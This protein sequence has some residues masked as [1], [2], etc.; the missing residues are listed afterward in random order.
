MKKTMLLLT[1]MSVILI[2][3]CKNI[4]FEKTK[5]GMEYKIYNDGKGR[6]LKKGDFVKFDYKITYNDSLINSSYNFIPG[7]DEVDTVGRYHDFSEV[8]SKMKIGDSLVCFQFVDSLMTQNQF[9]IPPY[10]KKGGKQ[11]MTIK[12]LDAFEGRENAIVD[13]QKE[14]EAYKN[15]ELKVIEKYL[16]TNKINAKNIGDKVY[17]EMISEGT[18]PAADSG[19][20]VGIKYTGY[21]L[22]GK[23]FDSNTDSTKQLQKHGMELFYFVAKQEGSVTGMLE[24]I[25]Q[26]KQGGKGRIFIPSIMAYGPQGNPPAIKS[27]ENIYFDIELVEVKDVPQQPAGPNPMAPG[28]PNGGQ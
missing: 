27:N 16:A 15:S 3:S 18:G 24:G 12:I 13:Y 11:K 20:L 6:Q 14:I 25:T 5:T 17:V 10:M 4:G 9:G 1:V 22:E 7:F 26:F 8:L 19:K 2:S 21:N 28:N 23:A